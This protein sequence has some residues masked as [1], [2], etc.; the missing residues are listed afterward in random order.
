MKTGFKNKIDHI[1]MQYLETA[2]W[3]D[4]EILREDN[5]DKYGGLG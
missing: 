4:E 5:E 1:L 3:T 2:L